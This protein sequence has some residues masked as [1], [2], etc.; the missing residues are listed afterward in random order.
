MINS[1][2]VVR[3]DHHGGAAVLN[4]GRASEVHLGLKQ[5]VVVEGRFMNAF[6]G[7]IHQ[8]YPFTGGV[9]RPAG[10]RQG[11]GL[12]LSDLRD[13]NQVKTWP[14]NFLILS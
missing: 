6:Q 8:T 3:V 4:D 1:H 7:V 14:L 10:N 13:C 2:V 5:G 11:F 9:Q 12:Q